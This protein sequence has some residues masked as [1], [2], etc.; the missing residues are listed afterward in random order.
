M[1]DY[2]IT[3]D[4]GA[5]D[6]LP[7]G[8]AAKVIKG[9][10]FTTEFTNI[11]TAVNSKA[12]TTG[13]TFTGAVTFDAA[14]TLNAD[15]TFDT[16]T[17]FVDVSENKVGIGNVAPATALD[18][19]GTVTASGIVL[20]DNEKATFGA[21]DDLQIYHDGNHSYIV[22]QGTGNLRLSANNF[23]L[24]SWD[25]NET[26]MSATTNAEVS[27]RFNN[28]EKLSTTAT[29]I[30]VTGTVTADGFQT[31]TS[32]TNY[33]LLAR[34][35][36]NVAAYIQNG[37]TGDVLH[38]RSGNMAA[39]QG[40]LHLKVANNGDISFYEDTGTTPKFFWDASA[41]SLG[42]GTT[43][44][45]KDL[46]VSNITGSSEIMISTSDTGTGSL[47][48]GDVTSGAVARGFLKY[49]HSDNSLQL[50][51]AQTEAMRID[52]SGNVGIGT[53]SPESNLHV[54]NTSLANGVITV[55]R[56]TKIK[57]TITAGN[58]TGLT[59]DVNNT[60]GG[61]EALRFSGNGTERMRIDSSGNVGIGTTSP[62]GKL[63]VNGGGTATSGGTFIVRQDGDTYADGI[64]LTSS[65]ATSHR[66]WKD[67]SG[68]LNIGPSNLPS[69]MV[70]DLSGNLLVG[71][72]NANNVSDGIR[73][74]PDGFI[75]AANTSG[76]VMYANRLTTDGSILSFQRDGAPVGSIGTTYQSGVRYMHIA[77]ASTGIG[78]YSGGIFPCDSSGTFANNSKDLGSSTVKWD[79]VYAT[80]GTIQSSDRNEKQDIAELSD[81]EQRVAVACKGLLRK[82]R[83]KY[84]VEEKGDEARIHFGIIA[85]DL[86]DAFTAEGLDAGDYAMFINSTWTDEETGEERSSMG[87]RY[88]E[89]LAFII[90]A[91]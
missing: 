57:G 26:Y 18:V 61:T 83:W 63:E 51:S 59:I 84:A 17:L 72:T 23:E 46:N 64:A 56:D 39:G 1:T 85:Q 12:D 66:L 49:N 81:A 29:G 19:T 88:S 67:S 52:A 31:D 74:K 82:F 45:L 53:T 16:N 4:F 65:N 48:F 75:S 20:S 90:S 42:I 21:S 86:Q 43:S 50:G 9:S 60:Q 22:E 55:E 8:N 3:T 7:S 80:N 34:N 36:E 68:R 27:L 89:L 70:Q 2:T 77:G 35:S 78:Y 40:V 69:A 32:N 91:I 28:A 38:A 73:L 76:P 33:N 14:V 71:T 87:V 6:S 13:D 79:D 15:V 24:R 30:D 10:E 62:A 5:K 25:T 54:Q 47:E 41:E 11:L 37:G 58:S 44:P